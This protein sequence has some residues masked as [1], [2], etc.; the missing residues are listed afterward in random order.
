MIPLWKK[1]YVHGVFIFFTDIF[2]Q[3]DPFYEYLSISYTQFN[4]TML[5][6]FLCIIK[7]RDVYL[8]WQPFYLLM[9][10]YYN[11]QA[12]DKLSTFTAKLY[13]VGWMRWLSG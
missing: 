13:K 9:F 11:V 8:M 5:Y 10:L 12:A 3:L 1:V 7:S 4:I 2:L 6:T